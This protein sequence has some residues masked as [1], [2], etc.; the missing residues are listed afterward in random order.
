MPSSTA[1]RYAVMS[2][3]M[4]VLCALFLFPVFWVV[5]S[6]FKGR[7]EL[8]MWPISFLPQSPTLENYVLAFE[9]GNF[10]LYFANSVFVA[11]IATLLTLVISL[12]AGYAFA[13]YRFR[14][15][16]V[17]FAMVMATMMIP[18]EII[19]I[20]VFRVIVNTG[21]YN[22]LWG[23]I[24]PAV[25]T[26]TGTFMMRQ[27]FISIPSDYMEAARI[28]GASETRTFVQIMSPL[29]MPTLTVLAIIS[30]MWRWNDYLWP[31][32]VVT[33][34]SN[35]TLQLALASFSGEYS[36]DWNSL[37]AM[38]VLSLIPTTTVFL[39]FQKRIIGGMTAGGI[40]G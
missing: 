2:V 21:M 8:F 22:T 39:I 33:S 14:L 19:M 5:I 32:L 7:S 28:D 15:R 38:S 23:V 24:I 26:P 9:K 36:V 4:T 25:A 40:K 17:L 37:L 6:S 29:V 35:Y 11:I 10:P 13:K 1:R 3:C 31:M 18:L 30:F 20:P 27:A 12:M 16:G 34:K